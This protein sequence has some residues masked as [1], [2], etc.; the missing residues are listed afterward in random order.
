MTITHDTARAI[1]PESG[2]FIGGDRVT[3]TSAGTMERVD[4]TTGEVL[5]EFPIADAADVD[6]AVQAGQKAFPAWRKVGADQRRQLLWRVAELIRRDENELK[7]LIA[8]ET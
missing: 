3:S 2:L 7:T 5:G 1:L 4:P 8:L 6:R